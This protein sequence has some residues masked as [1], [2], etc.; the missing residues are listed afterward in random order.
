MPTIA[1]Q[2]QDFE[3]A[4]FLKEEIESFK[5]NKI[6]ELQQANFT[7]DEI[8]KEFG[9]KPLDTKPIEM[10][11]D[12]V[13]VE[14]RQEKGSVYEQLK[15]IELTDPENET[16]KQKLVGDAFEPA[17][18]WK[19]GWGGG[20]WD[21]H[22][23]Y[24]G[25]NI[26]PEL[27]TESQFDDTGIIER[28]IQ[29]LATIIKDIPVY[30]AGAVP[31][32]FSPVPG[33]AIISAGL[34]GGSLR[35]TYL[36]AL[37]ND[38]VN[39]FSEWFDAFVKEGIKAGA[40]EA[41]QLY[42]ASKVPGFMG[43]Y[44]KS[45]VGN[46]FGQVVGFEGTG[47]LIE[48]KLPSKEQLTDSFI[49]FGT[50]GLAGKG[51]TKA[52][53]TIK[54]TDKDAVELFSDM[55]S[56]KTILEDHSSS[57][58]KNPR[59][60]GI[61]EEPRPEVQ[62]DKFKEGIVFETAAE[63]KLF[64][65]TRYT[66]IKEEIT[67][68]EVKNLLTKNLLDRFHPI[69]EILRRVD[70][71]KNPQGI[72]NIY[73]RFRT[74]VGMDYRA[75][76]FIEIATID[77]GLNNKGKSFNQIMKPIAESKQSYAEFNNYKIAK[78]V[79][80]LEQ[81]GIDS[82]FDVQAAKEVVNNK[83]LI[84][85]YEKTSKELD[86]YQK[87]LLE[88][89]KERGLISQEAFNSMLEANKNYIPFSR[90][91]ESKKGE[92]GYT[93]S[94]SNPLKRIKGAKGLDTFDPIETVYK[95]TFHLV[96]LAE[97]N[98]AL[99]EFF[100]FVE[101]NK[102]AFPDIN[103]KKAKTRAF[104]VDVKE[105]EN[106]FSTD[107]FKQE[108]TL[109]PIEELLLPE[110]IKA[111]IP[112]T[113]IIKEKVFKE[114]IDPKAL[115][116]FKIFRKEF[117]TPDETSVSV[118]RNGKFEVWEVG[119][120]L[121]EA[122]K[123]FDPRQMSMI[124]KY[125]SKPASWLRAG[126]TLSPD[127]VVANIARDTIS[128]TIF[129]KSGFVPIWSSLEGLGTLILGK[130]GV[131]KKS[132][133]IYQK[134]IR[135]GGMQSTL[136]SLDRK[137]YDKPAFDI[138]NQGPI[139]NKLTNPME[140]LRVVSELSE[141]M[142]RI[143]EFKNSY[144][145]AK[146]L[147]LSEREAIERGGFESRD[148]TIDYAK[149]GTKI[150]GLNQIVAFFNARLQGYAKIYDAFAKR[151]GRTMALITG[152]IILPSVYLWFANRDDERV[153]RLDEWVKDH[154]WIIATEDKLYKIA[155]PF[156]PGVVFGTGAE[157]FL[158]YWS[159]E[160]PND[161]NRFA[162]DFLWSNV[163]NVIPVPQ[164]ALPIAEAMF[165]YSLFKDTPL[166]P[167]YMDKNLPSKYQYTNY[168][169][170]TAK[171]IS[172]TINS[173]VGD[174]TK[175]DN[176]I[177]IDNVIKQWTGGI[178]GYVVREIDKALIKYGVID[179][180]IKPT[181]NLTGIPFVRAFDLRDPSGSSQYITNFYRS[182]DKI[183]KKFQAISVLEKRGDF[184]EAIKIREEIKDKNELYL[185]SLKDAISELNSVIRNIY[186]TKKYTPDEK[187]E[188][189]DEHYLLMIKTAKRGLDYINNKVEIEKKK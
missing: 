129:S 159:K 90:I 157:K 42:A 150:R 141:N 77:G 142:T 103:I 154:Y 40:K 88:Y 3:K 123:D 114:G 5:K 95:N 78:R 26:T 180:P 17:K 111:K 31:G 178:G 21:L 119:K 125:L 165:N 1:E 24:T 20:I 139:R 81:R 46:L 140:M 64:D 133:A 51:I 34:V 116:N 161:F 156:E 37:E 6:I 67:T 16:L 137:V 53:D 108:K 175:L 94:V 104:E 43:K 173:V 128:A 147:G 57:N 107:I 113:K 181:D 44:G 85:K 36:T 14:M 61:K 146:K 65:K 70:K 189:I 106:A 149:M 68:K 55:V 38:E 87:E 23:A 18:Y 102:E 84:E 121:A 62:P 168:T 126:A 45:F 148:I 97:R 143:A 171:L 134:W 82:G 185:I 76:T 79:V 117:L 96:K 176:P 56:D 12:E 105:L 145:K 54:K 153:Q 19:R 13:I 89:V 177:Y 187:R 59:S 182:F 29:N 75:G 164:A 41:A 48:R 10:H 39:S 174:Y 110:K 131:S 47:A 4:G 172:K 71:E 27:Y 49:L 9:H 28:N 112:K 166:V 101:K 179:D 100:N 184:E 115:E 80:E 163:K 83:K 25:N 91:I 8:L 170:E 135:S 30:A 58:I 188:L 35:K 86:N 52:I 99:I 151:P 50:L 183:N 122:M 155:K 7:D 158:D 124:N 169:S 15:Q 136:V 63:Q 167:Y 73:E 60:Y 127:F 162:K 132:Q 33:G 138:L 2:V 120:E 11:W 66:E 74:L 69:L 130:T 92:T 109:R 160:N 144:N 22:K 72:L 186:N 118:Y 32:F 93:S 152:G 98:A